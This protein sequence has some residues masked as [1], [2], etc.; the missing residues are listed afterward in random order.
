MQRIRVTRIRARLIINLQRARGQSNFEVVT[1]DQVERD[2]FDG[3][4]KSPNKYYF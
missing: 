1:C 2:L 4:D 3:I